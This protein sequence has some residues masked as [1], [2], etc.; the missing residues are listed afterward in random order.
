MAICRGGLTGSH[1]ITR[2]GARHVSVAHAISVAHGISSSSRISII[3]GVS[4]NGVSSRNMIWRAE[5]QQKKQQVLEVD[6]VA[7]FQHHKMQ[8]WP[9]RMVSSPVCNVVRWG[10]IIVSLSLTV[11]LE[12]AKRILDELY[13]CNHS[14][15]KTNSL[16]CKILATGDA[17]LD[18]PPLVTQ[19]LSFTKKYCL[20]TVMGATASGVASMA[21]AL[22]SLYRRR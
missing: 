12:N 3:I 17:Q 8:T 13:Q 19:F 9:E 4:N 22:C 21:A 15:H 14:Q 6:L 16:W 10:M 5:E 20:E 2:N 1:P 18:T 7:A 11:A